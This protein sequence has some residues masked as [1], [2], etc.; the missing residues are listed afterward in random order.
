MICFILF[1]FVS[2]AYILRTVVLFCIKSDLAE[3]NYHHISP[4]TYEI[5][6]MFS[7]AI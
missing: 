5:V 6:D 2:V 3:I 1:L 4:T 7:L